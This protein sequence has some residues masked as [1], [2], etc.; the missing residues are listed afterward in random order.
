[1]THDQQGTATLTMTVEDVLATVPGLSRRRL[2]FELAEGNLPSFKIGKYRCVKRSDLE[3]WVERLA[4]GNGHEHR[5]A[6]TQTSAP[7]RTTRKKAAK[8]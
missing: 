7:S 6:Q 5:P 3:A 8:K 2:F 1:M 4:T